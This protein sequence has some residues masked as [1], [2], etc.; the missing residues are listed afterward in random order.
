[1]TK[2][3]II[4]GATGAVGQQLL[5]LC[6]DNDRY[7]QVTVIARR[8][9][10]LAHPKL[11]WLEADLKTLDTLAVMPALA[12]GDAFCCLGTTI[13]A[14][15]S[16]QGFRRVDFDFVL[17]AA[18]FAQRCQINSFNMVSAL[19]ADSQSTVFYNRTKGDIETALIA[20]KLPHLRL[21]RP[22]LLKG[23]R[24]ELRWAEAVGNVVSTVL[25]PL[26]A[27]GLKKYQPLAIDALAR[28]LYHTADED[29]AVAVRV[30]ESDELQGY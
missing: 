26:F 27:L 25:K 18:Q 12:G 15:G 11:H 4:F 1:M 6:L 21:F 8:P 7:Q 3:A 13:K 22:S 17:A 29:D 9:T 24:A 10:S 2:Q 28:A 5:T 23:P 30:Y 14:A 19:G 20:Q 16:K